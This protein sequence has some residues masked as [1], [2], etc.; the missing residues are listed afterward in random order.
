MKRM[1]LA[2]IAACALAFASAAEARSADTSGSVA[3][4]PDQSTVES[5]TDDAFEVSHTFAARYYFE[6]RLNG[7]GTAQ[8]RL[9]FGKAFSKRRSVKIYLPFVTSFAAT[10]APKSGLGNIAFVYTDSVKGEAFDHALVGELWLPTVTNGVKSDDTQLRPH[11]DVRWRWSSGGLSLE[12]RFAQSVIVPPGSSWT[13]FYDLRAT[14]YVSTARSGAVA[15]LYEA[16]VNLARGGIFVSAIGP[17]VSANIGKAT[18]LSAFDIW[19]I[20]GNGQANLWRYRVQAQINAK[21]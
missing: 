13:S 1:W 8:Y 21:L 9:T 17:S 7:A 10:R 11:Y 3:A 20:G 18:T 4:N 16:R 15:L 12:N 5:P 14:P 6:S 2:G 19:G